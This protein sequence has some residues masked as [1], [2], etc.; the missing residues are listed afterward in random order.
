[1]LVA[2]T[3]VSGSGKSSLVF[4]ILDRAARQ[5]FFGASTKPG[6]HDEI[7]GLEYINKIITIDQSA[8][9]RTPRSNAA[10]YTD[11]FTYI[12]K[13]FAGTKDA[14]EK[15][16]PASHFSFNVAGGR[17][18]RCMGAGVLTI[19]MHFLPDVLVRCP[20]C[21]GNRFKKHIIE[22]EYNNVNISQVLEMTIENALKVFRDVPAVYTRLALMEKVGM[23][24]LRLGQPA[25]T[26]S[27]GEAQR[28]KLAKELSRRS[29]GHTLYLL[30]EPTTGLHVADVS[31]LLEVL[32]ELVDAGNTVI[33]IEHNVDIIRSSD[34][35]ID[36]GP[37]G[38]KKGG[39]IVAEG[40]PEDITKIKESY[41]GQALSL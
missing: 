32:H 20:D 19:E 18:E 7:T 16:I 9:G 2:V 4:D 1:M 14:K 37:D 30:D 28:V 27:G 41:T 34:W 39:Y 23:G 22:I 5:R 10:T 29:T 36:L 21:H 40:R 8:I 17:C 35:I 13:A 24:Y 38:G 11:V 6:K 15:Q 33:V 31:R 12:R 26:L 25:T 3:G